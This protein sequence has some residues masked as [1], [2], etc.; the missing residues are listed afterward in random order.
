ML[1]HTDED[2]LKF[3]GD[4]FSRSLVRWGSGEVAI[5]AVT[6][7]LLNLSEIRLQTPSGY[8]VDLLMELVGKG[9]KTKVNTYSLSERVLRNWGEA[10]HNVLNYCSKTV[11]PKC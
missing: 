4:M 5:K 9:N 8:E 2:L 1:K 11:K 6:S 3:K 10:W 7:E